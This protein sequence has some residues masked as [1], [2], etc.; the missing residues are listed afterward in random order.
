MNYKKIAIRESKEFFNL[1][2]LDFLYYFIDEIK[3]NYFI[4]YMNYSINE[5][6]KNLYNIYIEYD[7]IIDLDEYIVSNILNFKNNIKLFLNSYDIKYSNFYHNDVKYN[8]MSNVLDMRVFYINID[9]VYDINILYQLES[10]FYKEYLKYD[11]V[12]IV[13]Y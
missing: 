13:F 5:N 8:N 7:K 12:D 3:K 11:Y 1:N 10:H 4:S 6:E 2:S 9:D